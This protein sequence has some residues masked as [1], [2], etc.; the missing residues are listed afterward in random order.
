MLSILYFSS[1]YNYLLFHSIAE[2]F[3]I[4][5][6]F[7]VFILTWNS[8]AY[9]KNNYLLIVGTAY[10]FIGF[11]DLFHTLSYKG[12]QIFHDY[13]YYAN[14]LWIATR[15]LESITLLLAFIFVNS[16]KQ[17]NTYIIFVVYTAITIIIM[18][19]ILLWK[20]F[21]IC[22]IDGIGLT[23]F[24]IISEYTICGILF[25]SVIFLTKHRVNFDMKVYRWLLWSIFFAIIS[26]LS[27]TFYINNYGFSNLIGH[28]FKIASFYLI[29]K[30]V[31]EKGVRE[32][33]E[34]IFRELKLNENKLCE[35]NDILRN[36]AIIDGL[37]GLFNHRYL[38]EKMDEERDRCEKNTC[39]LSVIILDIDLF[40]KVN[41]TYGHL[42]G[43]E[44]IKSIAK[45]IKVNIRSSDIAGR[46]GGEEFLIILPETD[47]NSA[48]TLAEKIR[49][50]IEI[51][52]FINDIKITISGGVA[53]YNGEKVSEL[54][55]S[56]D[57]KLYTAKQTGRNKVQ[58]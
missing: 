39:Q 24:K 38:S 17:V 29:Y 43:D 7:T 48:Y 23:P 57:D 40:K 52:T 56:A 26:E 2:I 54:L 15:F 9:I 21:P 14:Q 10:L 34:L 1:L 22:F 16:K 19:S 36:K 44:I 55:K 30:A 4:C 11:L 53:Q 27:F 5:I 13:D 45:I 28:Y 47:L 35:Q 50:E 12:M 25:L 46:Y 20:I 49:Q 32:P 37:T 41:D 6:A 58:M 42:T 18:L 33:Y 31:I 8:A 51:T 3:S